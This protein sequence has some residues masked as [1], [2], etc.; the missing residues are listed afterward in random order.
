VDLDYTWMRQQGRV[1]A[2][3]PQPLPEL[4]AVS[5]LRAQQHGQCPSPEPI[6]CNLE[7]TTL[8]KTALLKNGVENYTDV[9]HSVEND[10]DNDSAEND[11]AENDGALGLIRPGQARFQRTM[12]RVELDAAAQV[13]EL[14]VTGTAA[15]VRVSLDGNPP[16]VLI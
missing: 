5:V 15:R 7:T 6:T 8:W 3:P 10:V 16:S 11:G 9:N 13:V 4:R 1:P 2:L 14:V 12:E